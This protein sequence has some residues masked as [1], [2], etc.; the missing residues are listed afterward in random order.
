MIK[1][2]RTIINKGERM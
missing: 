2:N 1:K